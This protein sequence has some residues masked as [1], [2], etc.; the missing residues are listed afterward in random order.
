MYTQHAIPMSLQRYAE[1]QQLLKWQ[2]TQAESLMYPSP[3]LSRYPF[4][5][6][7]TPFVRN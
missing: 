4:F 1:Y 5:M 6:S 2:Q 3:Y 7:P